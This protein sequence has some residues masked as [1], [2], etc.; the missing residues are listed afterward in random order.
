MVIN[1]TVEDMVYEFSMLDEVEGVLLAGSHATKT[2]D[3]D[4]DYDIYVYTSNEI[5]LE[6]RK[7][8]TSKYCNYMELNN[9][10][11]EKED[12]GILEEGNIP[13]EI[14]YRNLAWIDEILNSVL[15]EYK[16]STGYTTCFWSNFLNSIVLYDRN[17]KLKKLKQKYN[18]DYPKELKKNII[19][20]NYPLLKK[21]MPSYYN[22]IKKALKRNDFISVNH[23][24]AA[25]LAS[26][27]DIIFAINEMP[28]PGE[29]KLLRIIKDNNLKIPQEMYRNV[30]NILTYASTKEDNI[31]FEIDKIV[32]NLDTLL[33]SE[34]I[35]VEKLD[36]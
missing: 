35:E 9:S 25:F 5:L 15:L 13:V 22:Q 30:S 36:V 14:I 12:D 10:F 24:I 20:K 34:G 4:S 3:K 19:R 29:K 33:I 21:Q 28:H 32:N 11:W 31:L 6:K 23:R 16:V 2:N 18:I 17:G 1:K 26:Y 27:F 7:E 8:I